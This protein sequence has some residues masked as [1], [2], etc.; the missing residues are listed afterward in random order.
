MQS[1]NLTDLFLR[2]RGQLQLTSQQQAGILTL[3]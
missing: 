2:N 1:A 3:L